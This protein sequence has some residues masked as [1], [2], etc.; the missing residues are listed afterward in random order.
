VIGTS[1]AP[2][3]EAPRRP[4]ERDGRS[5]RATP[6]RWAASEILAP[7]SKLTATI[8]A[9]TV[10]VHRRP[11]GRPGGISHRGSHKKCPAAKSL[12]HGR[13]RKRDSL[14]RRI[15]GA[16]QPN[17]TAATDG[18]PLPFDLPAVCRKKL[19]VDF[20]GG[21]QSSDGGLLL[22]RAAE[23][24]VGVCARLAAAIPD[25]RVR[26]ASCMRCSRW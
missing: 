7:S 1:D 8:G 6:L 3:A 11:R 16:S 4:G 15:L 23:R 5:P 18:T 14:S 10:V 2:Q 19:T 25:R 17:A 9:F 24:K 26:T 22:L 21:A 13:G 20:S 12:F